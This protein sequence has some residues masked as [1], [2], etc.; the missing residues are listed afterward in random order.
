M[1]TFVCGLFLWLRFIYLKKSLKPTGTFSLFGVILAAMANQMDK[2]YLFELLHKYLE[3]TA[4][5]AERQLIERY[6]N[7]FESEPDVLALLTAEQK[8][9]LRK[10]LP[11]DIWKSVEREE[12][13][14]RRKTRAVMWKIGLA[15]GVAMILMIV[16]FRC[17]KSPLF[18]TAPHVKVQ[19]VDNK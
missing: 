11:A 19:A 5:E 12:I 14:I 15:V 8:N 9:E 6:Y 13:D 7:L 10:S 4:T 16:T 1:G 18:Q 17:W 2:H 3:G